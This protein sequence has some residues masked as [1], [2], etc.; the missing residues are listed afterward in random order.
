MPFQWNNETKDSDPKMT[1]YFHFICKQ[2]SCAR[3]R[4]FSFLSW[5]ESFRGAHFFRAVHFFIEAFRAAKRNDANRPTH[6]STVCF[7]SVVRVPFHERMHTRS[8]FW[9]TPCARCIHSNILIKWT[10]L[11]VSQWF[12]RAF[13]RMQIDE[14]WKW[15]TKLF[16]LGKMRFS[17]AFQ[18]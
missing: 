15:W 17:D 2:K 10:Q 5:A 6:N 3:R 1:K 4:S 16:R 11:V 12:E 14:N 8:N 18:F 7:S 9:G 13:R